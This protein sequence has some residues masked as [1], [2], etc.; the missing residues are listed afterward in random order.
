MGGGPYTVPVTISGA[1]G[2]SMM[3]LTLRYNPAVLRV[4]GVQEGSFMRQGGLASGFSQQVDA[5]NGR[6]DITFRRTGDMV[7][8]TGSNTVAAVLFDAVAAGSSTLSLS[9]A[10]AGPS[11]APVALQF[12]PTTITVR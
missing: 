1:T 2:V 9:G 4:R 10:A 8:A 6:I 5:V 3:S 12:S 7:G 11:G